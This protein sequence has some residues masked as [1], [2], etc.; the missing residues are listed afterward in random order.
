MELF[1]RTQQAFKQSRVFHRAMELALCSVLMFGRRTITGMLS[2]GGKQFEDWSAAY[3]IFENNRFNRQLFFAPVIEA[4]SDA[5]PDGSPFYTA[6]DDTIIRKRGKKIAGANW[7]RDP[8]GPQWHNNFIWGQRY[9]QMS[10]MLPDAK[11]A[12]RARGIPIDFIHAPTLKKPRKNASKE[13]W[14]EYNAA[15]KPDKVTVLGAKRLKELRD[16]IPCRKIICS[17]D[18]GF[19]NKEV[20][21][22]IPSNTAIIGRIRKDASLFASPESEG[23]IRRGRKKYYGAKLPTPEQIRQDESIPWQQVRAY[24]AGKM[25]EFDVKVMTPIRWKGSGDRDVLVL[26]IRPLAYRPKKGTKL[27][28]RNPAYLISTDP[29][30]P[31]EQLL[32]AYIWRWEIEVNFRDEKT[33]M[34][35]GQAGVR[36]ETAVQNLPAFQVATYSYTLLAAE[37]SGSDFL[38]P[39]AKWQRRLPAGRLP[40]S[41]IQSLFRTEFWLPHL[42]QNKSE[43]VLNP[44]A[45]QTHFFSIHSPN[46][47]ICSALNG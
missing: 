30:L 29:T 38:L 23:G 43:F 37:L 15:E 4:V 17:V 10:A 1:S 36:T 8:L 24:A 27:C 26:V 14:D 22:N 7:K 9:L 41:K 12:G 45:A 5:L 42:L 6:I 13:K 18:G 28:Y 16:Q 33:L 39:A 47:A 11:E 25:H 34:G 2:A 19:T 46:S 21:R 31:L 20:F 35:V 44:S 40:T 3:R 32:Q